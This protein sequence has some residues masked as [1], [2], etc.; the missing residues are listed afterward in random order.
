MKQLPKPFMKRPNFFEGVAVAVVLSMLAS[1]FALVLIPVFGRSGVAYVLITAIS[2]IYLIYLLARSKE[3][4]G[5]ITTIVLWMAVTGLVW[6]AGLPWFLLGVVQVGFIWLVRSLYFYSSIISALTDLALT[7]TSV[8]V[9]YW[10]A[11]HSGSLFLSAW[12][13]FLMQALFVAIPKQW[14]AGSGDHQPIQ[15]DAFQHAFRNA[16]AAVRKL[17]TLR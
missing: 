17:S 9:A 14:R 8:I 15:D 2:F 7:A 13:F 1:A 6:L 11:T 3:R 10:A 12:T 4:V 16:E 5:R